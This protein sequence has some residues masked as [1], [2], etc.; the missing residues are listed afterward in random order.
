M[1]FGML[2]ELEELRFNAV[3]RIAWQC[4]A[5]SKSLSSPRPLRWTL[6]RSL[7]AE[8]VNSLERCMPA[9]PLLV[10]GLGMFRDVKGVINQQAY[11]HKLITTSHT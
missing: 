8:A 2:F 7:A 5:S 3:G 10:F 4:L 6:M 1:L 11:H 9:I